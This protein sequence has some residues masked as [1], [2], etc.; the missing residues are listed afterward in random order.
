MYRKQMNL[1]LL[2][3][4]AAIFLCGACSSATSELRKTEAAENN[5]PAIV[6]ED[7]RVAAARELIEK[8]PDLPDGYTRLAA[9]YIR[10]ARET[11]DFSLNAKAETAVQRALEIAPADATAQKLRASLHL[12]FHRF[13]EA[14]AAGEK[15]RESY[16]KDAFVYG[17]L[18]DAHVEL[19]NY[20]EAVEA[21]QAMVDLK[22]NMESYARV[23]QL[24][25]LYGDSAG[26]I[27]AMTLAARIADPQNP[28]VQGWC[29][30]H[31]G[32]EYF[33]IGKPAEAEKQYDEALRIFP[34]Y[35]LALA[36]K[37]KT[38]AAQNDFDAAIKF[39]AEAQARVPLV[40]TI[41]ALGD[42][43]TRNGETEKARRQYDLAEVIE[44]QFGG[45]DRR[46]AALLWADRDLRLDEA[47]TIAAQENANRKDIFTADIYAW[48]LYKKGRF[49]EAKAAINRALHLKTKDARIFYHAG[50]IEKASGNQK[51]AKRFLSLALQTNPSF[52]VLQAEN[53]RAAL[54]E[55]K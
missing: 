19:G 2:V 49:Q 44:Q 5:S 52:D 10:R 37:A 9:A 31:L 7:A 46:R 39:Y 18:T 16:P 29:L 1:R 50:M 28:E 41:I 6:A 45:A 17:V 48:T 36:G 3:I 14:L 13:A 42:L 21:A 47:L 12:T 27:E 40:E 24:R 26:A 54:A 38:R 23:A 11:G 34:D 33:K 53:A 32:D 43:Y 35:H 15:L 20:Q 4:F 55:I 8:M 22:P 51:E 30:V 25:S